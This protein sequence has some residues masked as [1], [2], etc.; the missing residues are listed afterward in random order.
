MSIDMAVNVF[1]SESMSAPP[2][3][4]ALAVTV[5]S[6]TFGE[7]F[8]ISGLSGSTFF[9]CD[10]QFPKP[11]GV[12]AEGEAVLHIRTRDIQ[13]DAGHAIELVHRRA[14]L[15]VIVKRMAGDIHDHRARHL[16]KLRNLFIEE[17]IEADV[18]QP[19][20]I[21]HSRPHFDD[22]GWLISDSL[23]ARDRLSDKRAELRARSMKSAYSN[24]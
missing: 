19:D 10:D 2:S 16:L 9:T 17:S 24:A 18:R 15:D 23:L 22:A 1:T 3:M 7:S 8:T 4:A 12:G 14:G 13:L 5:T 11:A 20:R 21:Q 6:S